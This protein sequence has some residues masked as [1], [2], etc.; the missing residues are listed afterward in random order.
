MSDFFNLRRFGAYAAKQY[1]ENARRY[2][3]YLALLAGSFTLILLFLW[4]IG[5]ENDDAFGLFYMLAFIFL[6]IVLVIGDMA[7]MRNKGMMNLFNMV[8]VSTFERYLLMCINLF[9]VYPLAFTA[10][11]FLVSGTSAYVFDYGDAGNIFFWEYNWEFYFINSVI[12]AMGLFSGATNMKSHFWAGV[13]SF[14]TV[15]FVAAS[16]AWLPEML[17]CE[18]FEFG[19]FFGSINTT[20]SQGET[21]LSYRS[22]GVSPGMWNRIEDS[23]FILICLLSAILTVAGYFKMKERQVK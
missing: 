20:L 10:I 14:V 11:Y 19:A 12:F 13:A 6:G 7:Q 1:R 18:N 8:P 16:F 17:S 5:I 22:M 15:W 9:V 4:L 23:G 21:T 2:C 3:T